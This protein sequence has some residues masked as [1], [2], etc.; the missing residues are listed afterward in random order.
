VTGALT[1]AVALV[2]LT[3]VGAVLAL[4]E[5]GLTRLGQ[6]RA[7]ALAEE[8]MPGSE[9]VAALL[10]DTSRSLLPAALVR[11]FSELGAATIVVASIP[12]DAGAGAVIAIA[13]ATG[14]VLFV[15]VEAVPRSWALAHPRR[16]ALMT[17]PLVTLLGQVPPLRALAMVGGIVGRRNGHDVDAHDPTVVSEE[18]L[19]AMADVAVEE[20]VLEGDERRLI[21]SIIEF[22]DTV[23]REV[24]A[25]RPDMITI[26]SGDR[27]SD[28]IE[29]AISHGFSR[30]P[31]TGGNIDDVVGVVFA[32]DLMRVARDGGEAAPVRGYARPARFVPETKRV[33]ELLRE[34]QHE[35]FH[36]AIVVDEYGG[37]AG[38][39]TLEDLIEELVGEIV[40][41]FDV[42][43]PLVEPLP[44]GEVRVDARLPIDE[45]N[46]LLHADLPRGD[47]TTIGGLVFGQL[48]HVPSVGEGVVVDGY[49]LVA[50]KVIGRR[51]GKVR[52]QPVPP[53]SSTD[54]TGA[55]G[56]SERAESA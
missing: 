1:V 24:M 53:A 38:L 48:G 18:D 7:L 4:A 13:A 5:T 41:E 29:A 28:A 15:F 36:L 52:I 42:E 39:V 46:D 14:I 50:E 2:V 26:D 33:A 56:R 20:D 54:L 23:A 9:Q 22:G 3:G 34:M 32:K 40:D 31:V 19:R 12:E 47:W 35:K 51:I 10:S 25:P 30:I 45:C 43:D 6:V 27:V 11:L 17:A 49:R 37:T 55:A 44:G 8:G 21:H 16:A